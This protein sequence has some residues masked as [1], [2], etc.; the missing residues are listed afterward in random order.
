MY[1]ILVILFLRTIQCENITNNVNI[2]SRDTINDIALRNFVDDFINLLSVKKH[3]ANIEELKNK[4]KQIETYVTNKESVTSLLKSILNRTE[5]NETNFYKD[6]YENDSFRFLADTAPKSLY[7]KMKERMNRD[8]ILKVFIEKG[9]KMIGS[10][11]KAMGKD[12]FDK[13][14]LDEMVDKM[15]AEIP[16]DDHKYNAVANESIY[17]GKYS[18]IHISTVSVDLN[19]DSYNFSAYFFS[20]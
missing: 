13:E 7:L 2:E 12:N 20:L 11:R 5:L 17:W 15:I 9:G 19:Y 14:Q 6:L 10:G 16:G 18:E 8:D 1:F 3:A 4:L